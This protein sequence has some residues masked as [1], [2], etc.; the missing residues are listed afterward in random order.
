MKILTYKVMGY[1]S[2]YSSETED[3]EQRESLA[4]VTVE[5]PSDADIA[6]A[7]DIAYNGEYTIEDDGIEETTTP[8]AEERIEALE[9]AVTLLCMPDVSE[10]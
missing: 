6:R 4:E 10:V 8:T 7:K 2:V 1:T 3:A 5:N 9:A